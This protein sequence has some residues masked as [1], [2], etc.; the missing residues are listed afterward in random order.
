MI[1]YCCL[2]MIVLCPCMLSFMT[3]TPI[4]YEKLFSPLFVVVW[5]VRH[6]L[7]VQIAGNSCELENDTY[8]L[9]LYLCFRVSFSFAVSLWY[10]TLEHDSFLFVFCFLEIYGIVL[11]CLS[12]ELSIWIY[13]VEPVW[14]Y[15]LRIF[16]NI[17]RNMFALK[18]CVTPLEFK[19]F[20]FHDFN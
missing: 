19:M 20:Y 5:L 10:V 18:R 4:T 16:E 17:L 11:T 13:S 2:R 12:I 6:M 15:P 1:R 7:K 8:C 9:F 3:N 14:Y